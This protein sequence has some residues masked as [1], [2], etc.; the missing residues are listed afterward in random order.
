MSVHLQEHECVC[1]GTCLREEGEAGL[2]WPC[3]SQ[4]GCVLRVMALETG[5]PCFVSGSFPH[6][7]L[8]A[9]RQ[10]LSPI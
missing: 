9:L 7:K 6:H 1:V 10:A 2:A 8:C 5:P 4:E 3:H